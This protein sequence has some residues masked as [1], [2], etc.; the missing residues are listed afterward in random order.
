M[1]NKNTLKVLVALIVG[2]VP[3]VGAQPQAPSPGPAVEFSPNPVDFGYLAPGYNENVTL[4]VTNTGDSNLIITKDELSRL[5]PFYVADDECA[6]KVIKPGES[7]QIGLSF[8][9]ENYWTHDQA[10]YF[11]IFDNA[12]GGHQSVL[13]YGWDEPK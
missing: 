13:L 6:G 10:A 11:T 3:V 1:I 9:P 7:C 2:T 12:S 8:E 4:T 5:N